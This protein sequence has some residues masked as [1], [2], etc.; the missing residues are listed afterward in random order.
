MAT[1]EELYDRTNNS[2]LRNDIEMSL[3]SAAQTDIDASGA[4]ITYSLTLLNK[5]VRQALAQE[6]LAYLVVKH[7]DKDAPTN[8]EVDTAVAAIY[9]KLAVAGV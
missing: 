1:Y 5:R 4:T 2:S 8:G 9:A 3:L 7:P 6:V